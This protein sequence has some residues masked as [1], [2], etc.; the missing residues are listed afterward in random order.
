VIKKHLKLFSIYGGIV[1]TALEWFALLFF[2][3]QEPQFFTGEHPLSYF[4]T[5]P[6]T[7]IIF[8]LCY[9]GAAISFWLFANRHLKGLFRTPIKVFAFSMLAFAG[10]ALFPYDPVNTISATIHIILAQASFGSF[11]LGMGLMAWQSDDIH[12]KRVTYLAVIIS[13]ML[14]ITLIIQSNTSR[15]VLILEVGAW[16]MFQLWTIWISRHA[17]QRMR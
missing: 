5:L 17:Y 8:S 16:L 3:I 14:L 11:V 13:V 15:F 9:L 7:K 2:Y 10:L 4:A 6:E 12:F 1:A